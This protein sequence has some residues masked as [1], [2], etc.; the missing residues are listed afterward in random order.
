MAEF[1]FNIDQI[2]S[3]SLSQRDKTT[4]IIQSTPTED[5][6]TVSFLAQAQLGNN[7]DRRGYVS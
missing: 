2:A 7:R 4:E 6:R 3:N 1:N 5:N